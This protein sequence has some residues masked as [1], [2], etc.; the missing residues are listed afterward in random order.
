MKKDRQE[1][2]VDDILNSME[3]MQR[4]EAPHALFHSI[5]QRIE[6]NAKHIIPLRTVWAAAASILLLLTINVYLV[7]GS[8]VKSSPA[9][10]SDANMNSV[11]EYYQL[12]DEAI[13]L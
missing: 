2:F 11:I 10:P 5:E 4:A 6:A 7:L 9:Q 8:S 12:E 3:G 13:S 1:Q